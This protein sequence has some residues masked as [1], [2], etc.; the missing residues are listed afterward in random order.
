MEFEKAELKTVKFNLTVYS[1]I[2][3]KNQ[4]W[5]NNNNNNNNNNHNNQLFHVSEILR[6]CN[7][8]TMGYGIS[9]T[10]MISFTSTAKGFCEYTSISYTRIIRI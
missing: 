2:L 1:H 9:P 5:T 3:I 6:G 8:S 7:H 4:K 10:H